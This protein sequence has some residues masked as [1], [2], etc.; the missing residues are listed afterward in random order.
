MP[1]NAP[2]TMAPMAM[3]QTRS[4]S[5]AQDADV[6]RHMLEGVLHPTPTLDLG[7]DAVT[8]AV[9]ASWQESFDSG[10]AALAEG[11][12]TDAVGDFSEAIALRPRYAEA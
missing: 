5:D 2:P 1:S 3:Q 10:I 12:Y 4:A 11:R 9:G 8:A 6:I 7:S